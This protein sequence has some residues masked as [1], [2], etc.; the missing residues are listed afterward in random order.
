VVKFLLPKIDIKGELRLKDFGTMKKCNAWL[1][2]IGRG[3]SWDEHIE[4]AVAKSRA[5]LG[6]A[7]LFTLGGSNGLFL[8]D[9]A[10]PHHSLYTI[11]SDRFGGRHGHYAFNLIYFWRESMNTYCGLRR[12]STVQTYD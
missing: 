10:F 4:D 8:L 11:V 12:N 9:E 5:K 7:P 2:R 3:L 1:G 6:G